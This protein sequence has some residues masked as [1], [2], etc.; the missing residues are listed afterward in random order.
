MVWHSFMLNS[1]SYFADCI[2]FKN[3]N[4]WAMGMPWYAVNAAIDNDHFEYKPGANARELFEV[5]AGMQWAPDVKSY[6]VEISCP[7]CLKTSP[8][9][10]T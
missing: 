2:R 10:W 6:F 1:R 5:T 3:L 4:L 9:P 8:A 7:K